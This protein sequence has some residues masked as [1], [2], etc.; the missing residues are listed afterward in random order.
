MIYLVNSVT[1]SGFSLSRAAITWIAVD[2][3]LVAVVIVTVV[4]AC[5][6]WKSYSRKVIK[7]RRVSTLFVHVSTPLSRWDVASTFSYLEFT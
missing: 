2:I 7:E 3:S 6:V 1:G 5:F 4:V